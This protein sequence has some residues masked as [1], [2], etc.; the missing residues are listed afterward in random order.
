MDANTIAA[1][2]GGATV[3][4]AATLIGV[5]LGP[6]LQ[7]RHELAQWRRERL[8]ELC[9]DL[10]VAGTD[11]VQIGFN[12]TKEKSPI[13]VEN[14]LHYAYSGITLL[15]DELEDSAL[16]CRT[17]SMAVFNSNDTGREAAYNAANAAFG[18]FYRDAHNVLFDKRRPLIARLGRWIRSR[19]LIAS[20]RR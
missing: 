20:N 10:L 4:A 13:E 5:Y 15:S 7:A 12:R 6:Q 17:A 1:G 18:Q 2:I 16:A 8:L 3:G 14:R 9:S 11:I 19:A